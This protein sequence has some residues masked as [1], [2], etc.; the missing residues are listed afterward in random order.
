MLQNKKKMPV[1]KIL[2]FV[3]GFIILFIII[4]EVN[5]RQYVRSVQEIS[6]QI[7][8]SDELY[9][10]NEQD[11]FRIIREGYSFEKK[12]YIKDIDLK[13][14]E[15]IVERNFFIEKAEVY[16]DFIGNLQISITQKKL[17]GRILNNGITGNYITK[18]GSIIPLSDKFTARTV[19]IQFDKNISFK[20]NIIET[21][22]GKELFQFLDFID[23]NIFWKNQVSEIIFY[24]TGDIV[25]FTQVSRQ[26]V[27]FG[28]AKSIEDIEDKFKRIKVFYTK[29]LPSK[30]WNTYK[31]VNV[32]FKN[33]IICE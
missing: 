8:Y 24:S 26:I 16:Y 14:I 30:G 4:R 27:E 28:R 20:K 6:V 19:L 23:K 33:Q 7:D 22:I 1:Q 10:I 2:L 32:K 3:L 29:I 11:I 15:S 17:I 9:F 12:K 25:F 31:K 18:Q 13:E 5:R 21:N